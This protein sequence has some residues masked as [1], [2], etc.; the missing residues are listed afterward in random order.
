MKIRGTIC[1]SKNVYTDDDYYYISLHMDNRQ[2]LLNKIDLSSLGIYKDIVSSLIPIR[3]K[4]YIHDTPAGAHISIKNGKVGR[5][6]DV[7]LG[8]PEEAEIFESKLRITYL[9]DIQSINYPLF[10]IT[11]PVDIVDSHNTVYE[12]SKDK[13]KLHYT[14]GYYAKRI[15]FIKMSLIVSSFAAMIYIIFSNHVLF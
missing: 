12:S 2:N 9:S 1:K 13:E 4:K 7:Y 5:E 15:N 11:L 8:F 14:L 10:W 3:Y 6:V